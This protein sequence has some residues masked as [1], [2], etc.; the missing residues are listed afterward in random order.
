MAMPP[1]STPHDKFSDE[2][3]E[4]FPHQLVQ[5]KAWES[6]LLP[7]E[8]HNDV[9]SDRRLRGINIMRKWKIIKDCSEAWH[10][11]D[12]AQL[13]VPPR[14][15]HRDPC[16]YELHM[17]PRRCVA[18]ALFPRARQ[19]MLL[20]FFQQPTVWY[21]QRD[22]HKMSC[23]GLSALQRE[24]YNLLGAKLI[25]AEPVRISSRELFPSMKYR[26]NSEAP[27]FS[28]L[29]SLAEVFQYSAYSPRC[30]YPA[31]TYYRARAELN[32]REL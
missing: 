5:S 23:M 2:A 22:L 13:H 3:P 30:Q 19:V 8:A 1:P 4:E 15:L 6:Y 25:V 29:C 21:R 24:I 9:Y 31:D 7:Y 27:L 18:D 32:L 10:L 12:L 17:D 16:S 28:A 20:V 11:F 26:A 14:R